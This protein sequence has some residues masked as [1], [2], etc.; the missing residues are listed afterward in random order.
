MRLCNSKQ[1][2]LFRGLRRRR[3]LA[4]ARRRRPCRLQPTAL[5]L[6]GPPVRAGVRVH[7]LVEILLV[8]FILN[9]PDPFGCHGQVAGASFDDQEAQG[10]HFEFFRIGV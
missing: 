6:V 4:P 2:L 5:D 7:G 3:A 8:D 10:S 1:T 9:G